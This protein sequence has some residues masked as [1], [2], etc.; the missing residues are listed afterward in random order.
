MSFDVELNFCPVKLLW[1]LDVTS[2]GI[3]KNLS[4]AIDINV[5]DWS[6]VYLCK[7]SHEIDIDDIDLGVNWDSSAIDINEEEDCKGLFSFTFL[8]TLIWLILSLYNVSLFKTEVNS[9]SE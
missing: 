3:L 8:V 9:S 6:K 2:K 1:F 4:D 5:S 7:D